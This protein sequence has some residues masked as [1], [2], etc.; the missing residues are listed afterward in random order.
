MLNLTNS[1][2]EEKIKDEILIIYAK[3]AQVV[4]KSNINFGHI[5]FKWAVEGAQ[6]VKE[7]TD[8]F[9]NSPTEDNFRKLWSKDKLWAANMGGHATNV[10]KK[11]GL[12][13]IIQV[14]KEIK[15]A[16]EYN[17]EWEKQ[18]KLKGV[19]REFWGKLK[20]K[21]LENACAD[22]ALRFFGFKKPKDYND[23]KNKYEQF[24]E[25]YISIIGGKQATSFSINIELDQLFNFIDKYQSGDDDKV[26][27]ELYK[28][29]CVLIGQL[30]T[31]LL[32]ALKEIEKED[33]LITYN[34]SQA[35]ESL[36]LSE[37][38][39]DRILNAL[40]YKQNI[41]LAGPP[42]VGKT[43]VAKKIAYS[44]M[45]IKDDNRIE[46][47]QFHQSYSY[48]DFIR[49]Y[50]PTVEGKFTLHDGIFYR[51]CQKAINDPD[52]DYFFI[53]DE[54]NRGNLSKIFGELMM[55]IEKD[56]RGKEYAVPL[57]YNNGD[58]EK[59]YIPQNLYLIGTMNTADKS[60]AMV[61]YAL[62]RRF[63]FINMEPEF[64]E[65]FQKFI[66]D[67]GVPNNLVRRIVGNIE[68]LNRVISEDRKNLGNGY[69]VGHS[70][71]SPIEKGKYDIDWYSNII[72]NEI[73]PLLEEYW[74]DDL[75]KAEG[76]IN[77]LLS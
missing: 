63:C 52:N 37:E 19:L 40:K 11:N 23:F 74:F 77:K 12:D 17:S 15:K 70:F 53:I 32:T 51:F 59:F 21:P 69:L 16:N 41:I 3:L 36:F 73:K 33:K 55:L 72:K 5:G 57:A 4:E 60:L 46:M 10:L 62:R 8:V 67:M 14:I 30:K 48:E 43:F 56:K 18:L 65:K 76:E 9:L 13:K 45:G 64:G 31:P 54:I 7:A 2:E 61:D 66:I 26:D 22:N 29:L 71:F 25:K 49:G 1:V 38:E 50:R 44:I 27:N 6:K 39:F 75:E 42:G 24:Q 28:E 58:E 20:D 47:I 35:L 68:E 34:K